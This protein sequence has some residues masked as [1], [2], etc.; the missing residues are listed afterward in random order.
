[1]EL[2][3]L[4][5]SKAVLVALYYID[6]EANANEVIDWLDER[7][8]F[9]YKFLPEYKSIYNALYYNYRNSLVDKIGPFFVVRWPEQVSIVE[10]IVKNIDLD[11]IDGGDNNTNGSED[12]DED[13]EDNDASNAE[14]NG[15]SSWLSAYDAAMAAYSS[16]MEAYKIAMASI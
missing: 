6:H 5:L 9:F 10:N 14:S 2:K 7:D 8:Y 12:Y 16:A 13:D 3:E 1:M 4:P 15:S 11:D